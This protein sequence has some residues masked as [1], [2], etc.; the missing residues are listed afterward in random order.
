M[1]RLHDDLYAVTGSLGFETATELLA[2]TD[3]LVSGDGPLT[4]DLRGVDEVDI[5]GLALLIEWTRRA[6][7]TSRALHLI[8]PP[9][10]LLTLARISEVE[11]LLFGQ[12]S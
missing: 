11:G 8:N 2:R 4:L 3:E 12:R 1:E 9:A 5:A 7:S 6:Q 10:Q